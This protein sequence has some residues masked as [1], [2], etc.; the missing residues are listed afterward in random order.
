MA[1]VATMPQASHKAGFF[2]DYKDFLETSS[3]GAT[4]HRLN[5]RYHQII[6]QN[7]ALIKGKRCI[8]LGAHDG[9][10]SFAAIRGAGAAHCMGIEPRAELV[11]ESRRLFTR[12][13][14]PESAHEMTCGDCHT[15]LPRLGAQ[16]R[17]FD[18]GFCL[19]F[20]YHTP[21]PFEVLAGLA[22]LDCA[23]IIVDTAV[24]PNVLEP[25]VRYDIERTASTANLYVKNRGAALIS[26]PSLIAVKYFLKELGYTAHAVVPEMSIP[27]D[28]PDYRAGKRFTIVGT[29]N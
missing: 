9:R 15:E 26:V 16:G 20:L 18:V 4:P 23:T 5:F 27:G 12:H 25:I 8:D 28:C 11:A 19:G 1:N 3:V 13:G 21:R 22:A 7:A 29:R 6:E 17:K 24:L 14:V 10:W 2:D